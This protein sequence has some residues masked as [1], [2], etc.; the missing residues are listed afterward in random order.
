MEVMGSISLAGWLDIL[1]L[2][3]AVWFGIRSRNG[4]PRLEKDISG[5][6]AGS[7]S[8]TPPPDKQASRVT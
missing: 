7:A 2:A 4:A 8:C 6:L 1:V 5:K 3:P